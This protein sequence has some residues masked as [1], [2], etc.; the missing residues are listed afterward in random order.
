MLDNEQLAEILVKENYLTA[1]DLKK[2][3]QAAVSYKISLYDALLL[4]NIIER[5]LLGQALAEYYQVPFFDLATEKIDKDLLADIP[6]PVARSYR[7][8]PLL[9]K[10]GKV[11]VGLV[12][13]SDLAA[14]HLAEKKLGLR[15]QPVFVLAEDFE[16]ALG[17]YGASLAEEFERIT[18]QAANGSR[19]DKDEA[20]IK[21]VDLL[22]AKGFR[23]KASD[24]HIEPYAKK[25]M[26]RF[27]LD[28]VLHRVLTIDKDLAQAIITRVKIMA[29]LRTDEHRGAQD[30]KL[31]LTTDGQTLDVRVSIVPITEGE[32]V[33]LRLL[34]AHSQNLTLTNLGLSDGD[35]K[36][37]KQAIAKPHGMILVTGPTGSGKTTTLYA[38][39]NILNRVEVHIATI[40]DPVEYAIEG[41]SQIQVDSRT[42]LTFAAGLRSILRQDPDII[43]VGEIRDQE[44]AGIAV[45]SALTGHLVLSTLHTND[46]ATALPRLID[47]KVEPFLIA[48]TVNVV[49]AQRLV[50]KIC[51]KCRLSGP[52]TKAEA[53]ILNGETTIKAY[54]RKKGYKNLKKLTVYRGQGCRACDQTGYSGR[55]G[56]FEILVIKPAIRQLIMAKRD[57]EEIFQA[58]RQSG[59]TTM[60]EDGLAK[61]LTGLTSLEEVLRVTR[62]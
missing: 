53:A 42:N 61:V 59:L 8:L 36:I 26:V 31:R 48:S 28:G 38:A 19:T 60:L 39:L 57:A 40:E 52:L 22:L 14:W 15:V 49:I 33:V 55:V 62:N 35:F 4:E 6:E 27:R 12:D 10:K 2:A 44:T 25:I 41:V 56:V 45:N 5:R 1:A 13:P 11:L 17:A 47:M 30:G 51:P 18:K 3:R 16:Q 54:L 9:K 29:R 20:I 50:R 24:I 37:I 23:N 32:N 43:M 58:A 21:I 34:T 46:A 7:F